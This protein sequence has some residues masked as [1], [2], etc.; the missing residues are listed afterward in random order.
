MN[1]KRDLDCP[2][3]T[4]EE[5]KKKYHVEFSRTPRDERM[6]FRNPE[7]KGEE[8]IWNSKRNQPQWNEVFLVDYLRAGS[9]D[10]DN[11]FPG[12]LTIRKKRW[13]NACLGLRQSD[14]KGKVE[15]IAD[16]AWQIV[17]V[18]NDLV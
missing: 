8:Y 1:A 6:V 17:S 11:P 3:T 12:L 10:Y 18:R 2:F 9:K 5:L 7:Y 16:R 15:L 4:E 13:E 14:L